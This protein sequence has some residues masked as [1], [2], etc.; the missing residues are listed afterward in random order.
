MASSNDDGG[1]LPSSLQAALH[2]LVK[3]INSS[4]GGIQ[5]ILF[6]TSEG[7]PLGRIYG[8]DCV[9]TLN[10]EVLASVESTWAPV[11]KQFPLLGQGKEIRT[12]TA[13]YD[14]GNLIHIYQ[15]PLV[16]VCVCV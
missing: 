16:R 5:V 13:M 14:V 8:E 6:S 10:E 9:G 2:Q 15:S 11:S 12:A 4:S 7:V 3:R 1:L